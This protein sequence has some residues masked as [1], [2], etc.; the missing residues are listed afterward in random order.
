MN[1]VRSK[2]SKKFAGLI[3]S[4]RTSNGMKIPLGKAMIGRE[5]EKAVI[6]TLRSGWLIHGPKNEELED[7]FAKLLS[8]KYAI[9]VNSCASALFL[10]IKA[11]DITGEV[12]LPS[13]TFAASA[14]AIESAGATPVFADSE[15]E[16]LNID[17]KSIEE[18]INK[19]TEA[20]MP[21]HIA[22]LTCDMDPILKLAS[23]HKL[24]VIEDSAETIGGTYK[25]KQAGSMGVGCFSF[26]PTKNMT[27]GEGGMLTTND[28]DV[29]RKVRTL[30]AHGISKDT[31]ARL[32]DGR[33]GLRAAVLPGYNMRMS[34]LLAAIGVEQFKKLNKMN[35]LRRK[36]ANYLT[37]ALRALPVHTPVEPKGYTHVYQMYIIKVD[38]RRDEL[39]AYLKEHGIGVT[40]FSDP[41]VHEHPYYAEAY[42][43]RYKNKL[44]VAQKLAR[45]NIILPMYPEMTKVELDY[46]IDTIKL[47]YA[48]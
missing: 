13:F 22:G 15:F 43:K 5:E 7:N 3:K 47:F 6:E 24:A 9:T 46:M 40:V 30:M 17:P 41:L 27:T 38:E 20:I 33:S 18:L 12:I 44:P 25:T 2:I 28:E 35:V 29:A 16:T 4:D 32:A 1:P 19:K 42:G 11:Q 37:K 45:T 26:Y 23:E 21:V 8:V 36:H 34:N 31:H 10:A 48:S 14:N 39:L